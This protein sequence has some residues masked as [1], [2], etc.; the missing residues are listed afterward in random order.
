MTN[1]FKGSSNKLMR[2]INSDAKALT[3]YHIANSVFILESL[4]KHNKPFP[5]K[6][7]INYFCELTNREIERLSYLLNTIINEVLLEN[8]EFK[9]VKSEFKKKK[10]K[11]TFD[12][13]DTLCLYSG[14]VDSTIGIIKTKE[15]YNDILGV[16]VSHKDT[17]RITSIVRK[18]CDNLLKPKDIQV[19]KL[20]APGMGKEYSQTR[21]FL[22]VLYAGIISIFTTSNRLIISECGATMYQPK[23]SPLDT[24]TYTTNPYVL[25]TAKSII[26][27]ILKKEFEIITPFEDFTKTELMSLLQDDTIL[28][29]THSC[30]TG[31]W[32]INCGKCYACITR[33]IG[34]INLDLGINYFKNFF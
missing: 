13:L 27:I 8:I 26:Q 14:G 7:S 20:I 30:I 15:K 12:K 23:F 34:S 2:F 6:V 25:M 21:G 18:L 4:I 29:Q 22:Y 5:K 16:Y 1:L 24:V 9:F 19:R 11:L 17:G 33:M 28:S 3:L 31:R 32:G 10:L